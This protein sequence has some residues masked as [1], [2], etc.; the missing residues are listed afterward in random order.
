MPQ[1]DLVMGVAAYG[2]LPTA[3]AGH[4]SMQQHSQQLRQG[5]GG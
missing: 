3:L 2:N 1:A 5:E 4:G